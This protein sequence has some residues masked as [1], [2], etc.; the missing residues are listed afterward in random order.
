MYI[1]SLPGYGQSSRPDW[2]MGIRDMAAWTTWFVRDYGIR[3]PLSVVGFSIGGWIAAEIAVVN[4]HIFDKMVLLGAMGL[5]PENGEI[6]DYFMNSG[7]EA[8]IRSFHNPEQAPEFA[9]YYGED[10]SA[11]EAEQVEVNR[12][13]T[14]R[15]TWRPYMHSLTLAGL[16]KGVAT[17]TLLVWGQEDLIAPLSCCEQYQRAIPGATSK[18]IDDCGHLP[19]MEKPEEFAEAVGAFLAAKEKPN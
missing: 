7:K 5:K 10:W 15:L 3:V 8:F 11:E 18:I 6:F 4:P 1:P 9:E 13:M 16:L 12:E 19:E 14:S 17:P 2:L